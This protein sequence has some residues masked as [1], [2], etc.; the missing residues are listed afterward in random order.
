M[1]RPSE[2]PDLPQ[3]RIHELIAE[4]ER[5][6]DI[7]QTTTDA[8]VVT[9]GEGIVRF[10]NAAAEE[11]F[12]RPAASLIDGPFGYPITVGETAELDVLRPDGR[13]LIV[14]LRV[15]QS[16]WAGRSASIAS[17]RDVTE[18]R[19]A[20]ERERALIRETAARVEAETAERN[21][22]FLVE[23]GARLA[24]ALDYSVVL[25]TL[26]EL[27]VP[28]L[29][30][31]SIVDAAGSEGAFE[32]VGVAYCDADRVDLVQ[33]LRTITLQRA[34]NRVV[35][36]GKPE[37][38]HE[39]EN[40]LGQ[41]TDHEDSLAVLRELAPRS[42]M[43]LPLSARDRVLGTWTLLFTSSGRRYRERDLVFAEELAGR[44]AIAV[45]N[46]R[47]YQ[48]AQ[49][50]NRAKADFLRVMSHELRTPLNAIIG[51]A[52]L[53]L[54]GVPSSIPQKS[55]DY[56]QRMLSSAQR[57]L[58]VI[59]EIFTF[60]RIEAEREN[61]VIERIDAAQLCREAAGLIE[62]AAAAR[63]LAF[64]VTL[65]DAPIIFDSDHEKLRLVL[66]G[67]LSNAIKFT[68]QG[69]VGLE[70]T[71]TPTHV[72]FHVRDT[73]IGIAEPLKER[74]FDPFW[75]A[76]QSFTRRAE[77]TGLGLTVARGLTRLLGGDITVRSVV[78]QGSRFTLSLPLR[79]AE[80]L[81]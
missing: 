17:L 19:Q 35:Q 2:H 50:A 33:R 68:D 57:L 77:G 42:V 76:E 34:Y 59:E 8:I 12:G 71:S 73:G 39:A 52:E 55:A 66:L 53:L 36:S 67:L 45:D 5:L 25:R 75:Q 13:A 63:A 51:F 31:C 58:R 6:H 56:V 18:Q 40:V 11:L 28:F 44:A 79:S 1:A 7:I 20:E 16:R 69:E 3:S 61:L 41:F 26:S 62:R 43:I 64:R 46:A 54:L 81:H 48:E 78:G 10:V 32:R 74:I 23:A 22:L 15:G 65:P 30:D 60:S 21:A 24:A 29:A 38:T 80:L 47:L 9:D 4:N 27:A 37:L 49:I 14:E 70:L 72:Q